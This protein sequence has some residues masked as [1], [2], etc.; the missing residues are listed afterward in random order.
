MSVK[1]DQI[2]SANGGCLKALFLMTKIKRGVSWSFLILGY[3]V[4]KSFFYLNT[5]SYCSVFNQD[6]V[7]QT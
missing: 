2:D 1:E 7:F 5:L 6:F 3:H 4:P